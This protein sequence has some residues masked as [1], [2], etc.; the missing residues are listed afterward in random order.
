MSIRLNQVQ[1]C[2]E[3][4]EQACWSDAQLAKKCGVTVR[5]PE[6]HFLS[7]TRKSPKAWLGEERLRRAAELLQDDSSVKEVANRLGFTHQHHFSREFKR[8]QGYPPSQTTSSGAISGSG[9]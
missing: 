4:A 7:Q 5:T 3:L 2:R 6:R 9:G 1:N 8:H